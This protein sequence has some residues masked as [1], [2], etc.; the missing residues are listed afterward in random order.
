MLKTRSKSKLKEAATTGKRMPDDKA[1][2][3]YK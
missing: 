1:K 3:N 2:K